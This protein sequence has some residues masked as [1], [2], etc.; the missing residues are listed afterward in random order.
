MSNYFVR[1][2]Q[3]HSRKINIPTSSNSGGRILTCDDLGEMA[4][5][6]LE[7][8]PQSADRCFDRPPFGY[9][10]WCASLQLGSHSI[11]PFEPLPA[12]SNSPAGV[13]AFSL[14]ASTSA[15][16]GKNSHASVYHQ[17]RILPDFSQLLL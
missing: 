12:L 11:V 10:R 15:N 2:R 13:E 16:L 14:N 6:I 7:V 1:N 5:A 3:A 9:T 8:S 4:S 17:H